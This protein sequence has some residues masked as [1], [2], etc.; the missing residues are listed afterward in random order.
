MHSEHGTAGFL[1]AS[2]TD[3]EGRLSD[4]I[5]QDFVVAPFMLASSLDPVDEV[6]VVK[7]ARSVSVVDALKQ[8]VPQT[9]AQLTTIEVQD[10][11]EY[12][13]W[14]QDAVEIGTVCIPSISGAMQV[15]TVL[16]GLR[17]EHQGINCK[18][19]DD[20]VRKHFL[21][22]RSVIADVALPRADTAWIDWFGN[23]EV[24]P[25]V[26]DHHGREF[27]FGRI[28]TGAQPNLGMHPEILAFLEEQR[29]QA[30]ALVLDT[31][32]LLIGH[33]DEIVSFVPV[34]DRPGFR[35]LFPSTA[36]AKRI[37]AELTSAGLGDLVGLRTAW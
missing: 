15:V 9:G 20:A 34:Q 27:P 29:V 28:L 3:Q 22:R 4:T 33:V 13:V 17:A 32:W 24:S 6:L 19:L 37:L 18:P 36:L 16:P 21:R 14:I 11:D 35:V 2:L 10:G 25:P 30:P 26:V 5:S 23:L 8:I 12:D 1:V 7:N 31:S